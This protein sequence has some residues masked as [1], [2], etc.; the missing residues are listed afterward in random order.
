MTGFELQD[1]LASRGAE[2]PII[3]ITGH[4]DELPQ[5]ARVHGTCGYLRKPFD[6]K[7]L[8]ALLRPHLRAALVD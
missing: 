6:T 8:L 3:F 1:L 2:P 7:A 5:R 4:D